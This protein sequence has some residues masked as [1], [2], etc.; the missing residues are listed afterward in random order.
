MKAVRGAAGGVRLVQADEPAGDGELVAVRSV[1][2]CASDLRY[3]AAG[4][5]HVIGHEIAG[6]T[7]DGTPVIVEG[8]VSC[9]RCDWCA[10]GRAN[11][12]RLAGTRILGMTADGGMADY[13][14]APRRA[15]IPVPA[16]LGL[17]DASLAEPAAVAWHA[18]AKA[19]VSAQ[20]RVLVVGAGA[21]G[22]LAVLAARALGAP[23]VGLAARHPFQREAGERFGASAPDGQ[24]DAVIE[25]SGT[26]SGLAAAVGMARPQGTVSTIS[27]FPANV[28][29]PYRDAF[30]KEVCVVPSI[31]YAVAGGRHELA[32]AAAM[33]AARPDITAT[34]VTHRFGIDEASQA[35][36]VA[37]ARPPG[38]FKVVVHP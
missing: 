27:V 32:Q 7:A 33:L 34:L 10:Q 24:Y 30:L 1:S 12:C 9:G 22:I 31:A 2:I 14:R 6:V 4:S 23:E 5:E 28:T 17:A 35:F 3:L 38:T 20:T 18:C 11:L 25:A 15:L 8:F 16:G 19:G 36:A 13:Y 26:Q 37:A 21:I 29:W